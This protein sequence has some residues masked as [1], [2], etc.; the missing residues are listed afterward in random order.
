MKRK[1]YAMEV[2][3]VDSKVPRKQIFNTTKNY[4]ILDIH[5]LQGSIRRHKFAEAL[6]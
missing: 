2:K 3:A 6:C 4:V 5:T 1:V